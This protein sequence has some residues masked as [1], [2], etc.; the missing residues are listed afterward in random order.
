MF[1]ANIIKR[2]ISKNFSAQNDANFRKEK[3]QSLKWR[4]EKLDS[5][6]KSREKCKSNSNLLTS[7]CFSAL[8]VHSSQQN[9]RANQQIERLQKELESLKDT[10]KSLAEKVQVNLLENTYFRRALRDL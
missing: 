2:I 3:I 4:A 1:F 6:A 8:S 9:E 5:G 10:N 7:N